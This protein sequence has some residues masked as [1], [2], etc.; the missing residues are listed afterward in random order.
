MLRNLLYIVKARAAGLGTCGSDKS[1]I[2]NG[3][4]K[5]KKKKKFLKYTIRGYIYYV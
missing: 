5:K 3:N 1:S 2:I 4:L